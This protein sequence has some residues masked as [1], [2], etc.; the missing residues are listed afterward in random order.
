MSHLGELLSAYLDGETTAVE[1]ARVDEHLG[2]C[3]ECLADLNDL[4]EARSAI[5]SLPFL[6]MPDGIADR[7]N[8]TVVPLRRRPQTWAAA[9]AA[10]I[11]FAIGLATL[12]APVDAVAVSLSDMA[13][14][15]VARSSSEVGFAPGRIVL[16][17]DVVSPDGAE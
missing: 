8:A 6:H 14:R 15:H 4:H 16:P 9:A 12:M 10:V 2:Q 17:A 1:S 5:R 13:D 11:V 7:G 3:G